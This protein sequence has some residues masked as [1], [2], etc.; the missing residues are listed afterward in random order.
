MPPFENVALA[1]PQRSQHT[2]SWRWQ[3]KAADGT[4]TN[5]SLAGY[6]GVLAQI[7]TS[8]GG[9]L[10]AD[11]SAYVTLEPADDTPDYDPTGRVLLVLPATVCTTIN[12][13]GSWDL[14]LLAADPD[15]NL[16]LLA[17]PVTSEPAVSV[18]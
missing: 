13:D 4:I 14:F 2:R 5:Q 12:R 8:A 15:D 6:T 16:K 9:T 11:I 3:T 18:P 10:L 7:R 1:I 17:G